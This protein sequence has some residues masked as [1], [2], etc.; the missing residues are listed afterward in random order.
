MQ[1]DDYRQKFVKLLRDTIIP[2]YNDISSKHKSYHRLNGYI[3]ENMPKSL[4]R[5]RSTGTHN[6]K[7]LRR[8]LIPVTK[9]SERGMFS[10][11]QIAVK[12]RIAGRSKTQHGTYRVGRV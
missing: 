12:S 1:Q 8:S 5:Y 9:P 4:F 2:A 7:A 11:S 10:D 6:I 3:K